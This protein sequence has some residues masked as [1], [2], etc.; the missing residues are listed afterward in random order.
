MTRQM[1]RCLHR[2]RLIVSQS[3]QINKIVFIR[4]VQSCYRPSNRD[5]TVL[6]RKKYRKR[7]HRRYDDEPLS[8]RF[9]D[10]LFVKK[11]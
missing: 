1:T 5:W 10:T 2:D 6:V 11:A 8:H 9:I 7:A 4:F 3:S